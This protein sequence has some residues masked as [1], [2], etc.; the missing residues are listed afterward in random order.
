MF[1]IQIENSFGIFTSV[2]ILLSLDVSCRCYRSLCIWGQY[3]L[4]A[5]W[6]HKLWVHY[7]WYIA[8]ALST[9]YAQSENNMT[10][11]TIN[12]ILNYIDY[13]VSQHELGV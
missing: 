1:P 5:L 7:I 9:T 10:L 2:F 3:I 13:L 8:I 11:L 6:S 12:I 4:S